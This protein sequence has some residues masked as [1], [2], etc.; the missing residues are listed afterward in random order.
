[1]KPPQSILLGMIW[2]ILYPTPVR[3]ES[4]LCRTDLDRQIEALRHPRDRW[5]VLVETLSPPRTLYRRHADRYFIGAS[6]VKLLTTA[7]A[8]SQLGAN[9]RVR[10]AVYATENGLH[11]VGR[12]DPSLSTEQLASLA[13]QVREAGIERV[14]RLIGDDTYFRGAIVHPNWEWED[15]HA[16]YGAPVNSLIANRNAIALKVIPQQLGQPL[17]LDWLD[18]RNALRMR[19]DNRTVTVAKDQ[20]EFLQL[21]RSLAH[22][23][24]QLHGQLVVGSEPEEIAIAVPDP[25][26]HFLR[27]F[28]R[29]LEQAGVT[30]GR[31]E[32]GGDPK[33]ILREPVAVVSSPPLSELVND[34][35]RFSDNLYAEVLLRWLGVN[36]EQ[37][38]QSTLAAGLEQ[39]QQ[40]LS[41]LGVE[42]QS[43]RLADGS[44]LS[45][46][47]LVS[48]EAIVQ[49]LRGMANSP[50]AA[51]YRDSLPLGGE[52]GTLRS[53]FR[54][55]PVRGRVRA[56]T[57]TLTGV[58]ALSGYLTMG[59]RSLIFSILINHSPESA[60]DQRQAI[61]RI[62]TQLMHLR[63]C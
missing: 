50:H 31:V 47:N 10:T 9:F 59:D 20:A 23:S 25:T 62:V 8:L 6:N 29:S 53:R 39:L 3:A 48:P 43:H 60:T 34:T 32:V 13:R 4:H 63:D 55:S 15:I 33:G 35:N 61:D 7:A 41:D 28:R 30:V 11:V 24:M 21:D 12:G 19:I 42:P 36:R 46:Q 18:P 22:P 2:L 40:T 38:R 54:N 5:G 44:G 52:S 27:Q 37:E 57:G 58:S 17:R 45:R 56:K 26:W 49:T 1:M 51:I 16:G 14:S